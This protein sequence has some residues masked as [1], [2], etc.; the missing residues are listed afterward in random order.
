MH[1]PDITIS[2][3]RQTERALRLNVSSWARRAREP[4]KW[5]I[6]RR[7][8]RSPFGVR[9]NLRSLVGTVFLVE[10]FIE[11]LFHEVDGYGE[12]Y[13]HVTS[14]SGENGRIDTD[15]LAINI[16]QWAARISGIDCRIRLNKVFIVQNSHI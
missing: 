12:P 5:A 9:V 4:V 11:D 1:Q 8:A 3:W 7:N 6:R 13:A 15:D 2:M 10:R 14:A 16:H